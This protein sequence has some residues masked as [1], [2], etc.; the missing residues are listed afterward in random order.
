M[1]LCVC[2][3]LPQS[4]LQFRARF[5]LTPGVPQQDK[6][7]TEHKRI[8]KQN[9]VFIMASTERLKSSDKEWKAVNE[10]Y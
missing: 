9:S 10:R 4:G 1:C 7:F 3:V 8:I 2:D 6:A 5:C